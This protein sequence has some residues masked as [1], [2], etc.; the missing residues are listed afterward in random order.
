EDGIRVHGVLRRHLP[1]ER[2]TR[3][4]LGYY[5]TRRNRDRGWMQLTLKA[6]RQSLRIDSQIEGFERI[7][8]RA[9]RAADAHGVAL[10]NTTRENLQALES[11]AG[12]AN[13]D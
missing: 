8:H 7:V 12:G 13:R 9:A 11:F 4:T 10:D 1:W 6:G 3:C 2:L 5:S